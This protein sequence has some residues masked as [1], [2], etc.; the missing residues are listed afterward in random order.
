MASHG[1]LRGPNSLHVELVIYFINRI[2]FDEQSR[3]SLSLYLYIRNI[4]FFIV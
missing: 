4:V 1:T 3:G 2:V